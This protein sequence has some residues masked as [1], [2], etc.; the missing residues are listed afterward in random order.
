VAHP[1]EAAAY[2]ALKSD[3]ARRH[4]RSTRRYRAGKAR[5]L[6]GANDRAERWAAATG[7][8]DPTGGG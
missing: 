8:A 6:A 7:R 2:Q 1:A 4:P 5:R 3:L